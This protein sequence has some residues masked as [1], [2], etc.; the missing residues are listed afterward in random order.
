MTDGTQGMR[1]LGESI[2]YVVIVSLL[3]FS[4]MAYLLARHGYLRRAAVHQRA[5]KIDIDNSFDGA[6]PTITVLVPRT[7]RTP[8]S[9]AR[10]CCRRR[11]RSSP[12]SRSPC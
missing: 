10:R 2:T 4:A 5:A 11:C 8:A 7:A 9:S 6:T 12:T 3:T 1:F